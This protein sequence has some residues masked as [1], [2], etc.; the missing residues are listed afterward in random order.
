MLR[1][2]WIENFKSYKT[3]Q[4]LSLSPLTLM[5]G[6]NAAGKSNAI[7]ALKF[8]SWFVGGEK[9]STI[10]NRIDNSERIFR[11]DVRD[12]VCM[13][14]SENF[15]FKIYFENKSSYSFSVGIKD[16]EYLFLANE[17]LKNTDNQIIY[18]TKLSEKKVSNNNLTE[19]DS[20]E[21]KVFPNFLSKQPPTFRFI[22]QRESAVINDMP[23]ILSIANHQ[24]KGSTDDTKI[25]INQV[26]NELQ[27]IKFFDFIPSSMRGFSLI[28]NKLNKMG[29]NLSGVLKYLYNEGKI[30]EVMDFVRELPEQEFIGLEFFEDNRERFSLELI[31]KFGLDSNVKNWSI[32]LLSDGTVRVLAIAAALLTSSEGTTLVLEELDNGIHPSKVKSLLDKIYKYAES[33][34]ISL[35]ITTHNPALM[36]GLP[37]KALGDVVFC[38]RDPKEGNS[39]LTRLSDLDDYVGLVS[40]GPLGELVTQGIVDRFVKNPITKD[41]KKQNALDWLALMRGEAHE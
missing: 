36:D 35:I 17:E 29:S 30:D 3:K 39:C 37:D 22:T 20:M 10:Q 24:F 33:K 5:V 1:S 26:I 8:I 21:V 11:G 9:L 25:L 14:G 19:T 34:K 7:E 4:Q 12:L 27:Y 13:S 32:E 31:E 18:S 15:K 2:I 23:H 6:A 16:K 41:Q 28:S 40:Q 38:Y